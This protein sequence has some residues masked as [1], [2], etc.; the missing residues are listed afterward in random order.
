M[1]VL[2]DKCMCCLEA[3]TNPGESFKDKMRDPQEA[4]ACLSTA[5]T[6]GNAICARRPCSLAA[7]RRW[8]ARR[9]RRNCDHTLGR[10][11][12]WSG[13]V[14]GDQRLLIN[15]LFVIR[16]HMLKPNANNNVCLLPFHTISTKSNGLADEARGTT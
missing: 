10:V 9:G 14:L 16:D 8:F 13:R 6:T 11:S 1:N 4:I 3:K 2:V 12:L 5:A 15:A 7:A